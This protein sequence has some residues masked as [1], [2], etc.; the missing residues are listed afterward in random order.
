[1]QFPGRHVAI[2]GLGKSGYESALFLK[3][4]GYEVFVSDSANRAD[5]CERAALLEKNGIQVET[6][7]HTHERILHSDWI[8]ISPGISPQ[9]PIFRAAGARKIPLFSE[10]EVASRYC[11]TSQIIAVTGTAGKTTVSTL[12][13]RIFSKAGLPVISC[14]NIGN[15]W[16]GEIS[17]I[18][19]DH[20]VV[21]EISS[22]QLATSE[23]FHPRV[24]ILLNLSPNHQ[25]WHADMEEYVEAKLRLFRNQIE[26]DYA[27]IRKED[28]DRFF[29]TV[30]FSAQTIYF[31]RNIDD[32]GLAA[33]QNT[34]EVVVCLVARLFGISDALSHPV[35]RAFEGIEHRLEQVA[36]W[37]QVSYVND[38]KCTS[39]AS[40][41]WALEK[42]PDSKVILIA[43]GHP[44]IEDFSSLR[45]WISRKVKHAILVG[46]ARELLRRS[47]NGACPLYEVLDF[48]DAVVQAHGFA[49]AG[50]IVLLSPACASFDMFQNYEERGKV[51]KSIVRELTG[52]KESLPASEVTPTR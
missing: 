10:I 23:S 8:L 20:F 5:V 4:K 6:G 29:P 9:T 19:K 12:I 49:G 52:S 40:L 47:W 30:D 18:G 14:G 21:L 46:E 39:P 17:K 3:R 16:V 26:T 27:I 32:Q 13:A 38:S 36:C 45:P 37:R 35:I 28:K 50:D 33:C 31:D 25:D 15:P 1:M 48:R 41:V 51:F 22:F 42:F 44:K 11:P 34:N 7:S 24:A 2:L 43:G